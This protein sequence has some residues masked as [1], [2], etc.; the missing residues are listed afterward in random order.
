MRLSRI[1][2]LFQDRIKDEHNYA[3]SQDG[4]INIDKKSS[5]SASRKKTNIKRWL[6]VSLDI[7]EQYFYVL[8]IRP[9]LTL[10]VVLFGLGIVGIITLAVISNYLYTYNFDLFISSGFLISTYIIIIS[11]I[12]L[13]VVFIHSLVTRERLGI[14]HEVI[15]HQKNYNKKHSIFPFFAHDLSFIIVF[16]LCLLILHILSLFSSYV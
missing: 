16:L 10:F 9:F 7:L 8:I 13:A 14:V 1:K 5:R 11:S 15:P 4:A 6:S 12:I 2:A 3:D